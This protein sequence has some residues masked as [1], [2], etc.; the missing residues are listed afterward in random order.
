MA[1]KK[2]SLSERLPWYRDK[3]YTG[4]LTEK[5]KRLLDSFRLQE[6]HPAAKYSDLP[7]EV[8]SYINELEIAVYDAKQGNLVMWCAFVSL[9]GILGI[10]REYWYPTWYGPLNYILAAG[11]VVGPWL[12]YRWKFKENANEFM[13]M[14]DPAFPTNEALKRYWDIQCISMSRR[15]GKE[16]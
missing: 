8:Q 15:Y 14:E 1:R 13:P 4:T 2:P 10:L 3:R 6:E 7:E 16:N 9:M 12:Y 11:F 5:D